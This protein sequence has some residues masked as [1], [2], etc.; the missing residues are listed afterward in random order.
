MTF[1]THKHCCRG[2]ESCCRGDSMVSSFL[3]TATFVTVQADLLLW[4]S[5]TTRCTFS[6]SPSSMELKQHY[7]CTKCKSFMKQRKRLSIL[8]EKD[9]MHTYSMYALP[10]CHLLPALPAA[11]P[12]SKLTWILDSRLCE[13]SLANVDE[14]RPH[15]NLTSGQTYRWAQCWQCAERHSR[16]EDYGFSPATAPPEVWWSPDRGDQW[17]RS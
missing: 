12:S 17:N 6:S 2:Q 13:D 11:E 9:F 8:R 1:Q 5:K 14:F 15:Y 16:T 7:F 4:Y 3:C 10:W